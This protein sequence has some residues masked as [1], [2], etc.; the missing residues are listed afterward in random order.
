MQFAFAEISTALARPRILKG[1]PA[2]PGHFGCLDPSPDRSRLPDQDLDVRHPGYGL[3]ASKGYGTAR[4]AEAW[5]GLAQAPCTAPVS[6][7]FSG[8]CGA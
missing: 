8:A 3:P 5:P 1:R 2:E 4:P 7:P 6:G